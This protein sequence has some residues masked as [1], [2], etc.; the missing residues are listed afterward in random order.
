MRLRDIESRLSRVERILDGMKSRLD[1]IEAIVRESLDSGYDE[2]YS[3]WG[4]SDLF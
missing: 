4:E 2:D 1:D 3:D